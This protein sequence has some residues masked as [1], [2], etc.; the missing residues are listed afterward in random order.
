MAV[1]VSYVEEIFIAHLGSQVDSA[2][3]MIALGIECPLKRS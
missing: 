3:A 1:L 2:G